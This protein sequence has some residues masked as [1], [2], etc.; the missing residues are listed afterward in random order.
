MSL[1][2]GGASSSPGSVGWSSS[3]LPRSTAGRS[4]VTVTAGPFAARMAGSFVPHCYDILE[5]V[6][7]WV[8]WAVTLLMVGGGAI[9]ARIAAAR[10]IE[11]MRGRLAPAELLLDFTALFSCGLTLIFVQFVDQYF[12]VYLPCAVIVVAKSVEDLLVAMARRGGR[13]LRAAVGRG[14]R[15]DA[16]RPRQ[17]R[18]DVD[19]RRAPPRGGGAR[20]PYLFRLE[21]VVLLGVR[22]L[23]CG[24][25]M[26][27]PRPRMPSCSGGG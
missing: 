16:G 8:R 11:A 2:H 14:G 22:R 13:L 23:T 24:P 26:P 27:R 21:V 18:G 1:L 3:R 9:F 7:E 10:L 4:S 19:P 6:P 20:R 15:M 17:G 12:L 5:V 25:A